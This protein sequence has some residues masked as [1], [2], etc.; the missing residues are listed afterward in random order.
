MQAALQAIEYYLPEQVLSNTQLAAEFPDWPVEKI[1]AKTGIAERRIA[2]P[3]ECASDL[4]FAAVRRLFASGAC[5][6]SEVDYL[7]LCTQ[8]PD[9]FL[10]T[11]ACLL[12]DRLGLPTTAGALDF[13]LGCSGFVYGLGLAQG[14]IATGQAA[15]VLL[16]TAETYSKFIHPQDRSVRTIFGDAAAASL[17]SAADEAAP[18][19]GPFE[20]GTDGAGAKN[21]IVPTGGMR[22]ARTPESAAAVEEPDGSRRSPDNLYMNGAELFS[23]TLRAVPE[24][25]DRLL[26][27]SGRRI[28]DVDLFVFHQANRFMLEHLRRKLRIPAER[29]CLALESCGNTVSSTIPIALK[30][31]AQRG[32][33]QAGHL[34]MAVGFGVG[35]SW[36]AGFLRWRG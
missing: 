22:R 25:V 24:C 36:G 33:L 8:S 18:C 32:Q 17:V 10:P 1:E 12:Q 5:R 16:V 11:T 28:E 27:K 7:L 19:L 31:A 14:L 26:A 20:F 4:A 3:E 9:Y 30:L 6:A 15:K 34:V 23:F 35:Y 21:L 13:N 29:F 2:G